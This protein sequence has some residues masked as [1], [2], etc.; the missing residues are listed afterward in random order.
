MSRCNVVRDISMPPSRIGLVKGYD[1]FLCR[2]L[3]EYDFN[4][5]TTRRLSL[6]GSSGYGKPC[7]GLVH[8]KAS[9]SR[10]YGII[11]AG[12]DNNLFAFTR[13]GKYQRCR[14]GGDTFFRCLEE[15]I[16]SAVKYHEFLTE[17]DVGISFMSS[18]K[19]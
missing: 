14:I 1:R 13:S 8:S 18:L 2:S 7:F 9:G 6:I 12:S 19:K 17:T 3:R 11:P 5:A 15:G 16:L 4:T 10:T